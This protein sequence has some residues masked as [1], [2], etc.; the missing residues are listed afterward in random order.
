MS[1]GTVTRSVESPDGST[2]VTLLGKALHVAG[3]PAH[4]I[5]EG[6]TLAARHLHL[7]GQFFS[8][9]TALFASYEGPGGRVTV[10]ERLEPAAVNLVR[11]RRLDDLLDNLEDQTLPPHTLAERL[12][13]I[14]D[15]PA[16]YGP[17][18]VVVGFALASAGAARFLGGGWP[19]IIGGLVIGL[20][21]GLLSLATGR[22]SG[23]ERTFEP[24]AA[25]V[26]ALL[27]GGLAVLLGPVAVPTVTLAGLI[28]LVPGLSLT[29]AMTELATRQLVSGSARLAGAAIVFLGLTF[30]AALGT[31]LATAMLG[32]APPVTLD[33]GPLWTEL[34]ALLVATAGFTV[35]FRA[36]W[37]QAH[38]LL[39]GG[40]V[41]VGGIHLGHAMLGPE[42]GPFVG[43]TFVGLA[44]NL[45]ARVLRR[46]AATVHLPGL[47]LLVPGSLG[48]RG[49]SELLAEDVLSGVQ[50]AF[51]AAIVAVALAT[52]ML[53]ANVIL[54]PRRVL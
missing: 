48:F 17:S 29:T 33:P 46:P 27:A 4:R 28:V 43:A 51:A 54:P 36:H 22:F 2:L 7:R 38:W 50:S 21:T 19:E 3:S 12:R 47:I 52:G 6:M 30:G 45:Y 8:T 15:A 53:L 41:A 13:S 42:L 5:E 49:L 25:F 18:S 10:L 35:L 23:L 14:V 24:I 31:R 9:P 32:P 1:G 39:V 16:P 34:L 26:A 40:A 20:V 11:L 44:G 37:K